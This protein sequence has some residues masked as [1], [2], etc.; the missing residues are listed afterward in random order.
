[1]MIAI[2]LN[3]LVITLMYFPHFEGVIWLE[4]L[5]QFF[6]LLFI[7]EAIVKIQD[8]KPKGY[9]ADPWN[10]FDFFVVIA[11]LPTLLMH[12]F[13]IPDT[14]LLLLLRLFRL[15]RLVRF[16][17]FVPHLQKIIAGL[18]RA[19]KASLFVLLALFFLN[20]LLAIFTCHFYGARAPEYFGDPL[21]AAYSIFQ[22][23]TVEGWNEI[24]QAITQEGDHPVLIGVTRLY[25][26]LVVLIG[27]IFGMSLANAVF[28]DE[29]TMDNTDAIEDKINNMQQ[30]L[31]ELK[32]LLQ[33]QQT[34]KE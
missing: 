16:I 7:V 18:G 24:P 1:M 26:A 31:E 9:F 21:V 3:A 34:D 5:D 30:Q 25:F 23:F 4:L 10:R 20:F 2:L 15:V 17:S 13:P 11:S 12:F 6:I 32:H 19:L 14:S 33:Q 29:M 8:L 28:V 22:L 27:G